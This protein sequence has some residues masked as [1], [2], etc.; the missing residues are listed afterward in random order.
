MFY[1]VMIIKHIS[2][3]KAKGLRTRVYAK[4]IRQNTHKHTYSKQWFPRRVSWFPK[5]KTSGK[6]VSKKHLI[7]KVIHRRI[8]F[9]TLNINSPCGTE[10][11]IFFFFF[12]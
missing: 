10:E 12:S 7:L 1:I 11:K 8:P 2:K 3:S 6:N 5:A 4:V 9:R